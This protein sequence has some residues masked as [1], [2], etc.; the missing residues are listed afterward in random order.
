MDPTLEQ[1]LESLRLLILNNPTLKWIQDHELVFG[2]KLAKK[3]ADL[4]DQSVISVWRDEAEA[5]EA[6]KKRG[7]TV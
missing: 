6:A 7:L 3:I 1:T 5:Y 4:A 2:D